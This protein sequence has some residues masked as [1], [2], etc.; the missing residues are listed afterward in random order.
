MEEGTKK[1]SS[2][3]VNTKDD[4]DHKCYTLKYYTQCLMKN[5]PTLIEALFA[6]SPIITTKYMQPIL[7]NIDLFI[8]KK[9]FDS[10]LMIRVLSV[11]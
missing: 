2:K 6:P 10:F 4:I 3:R 8:S 7:D 9:V 11:K 1:S 5:N